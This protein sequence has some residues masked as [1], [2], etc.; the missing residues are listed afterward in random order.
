M[1]SFTSLCKTLLLYKRFFAHIPPQIWKKCFE[2]E[3]KQT[4]CQ[5][6][7]RV[8]YNTENSCISEGLALTKKQANAHE[9]DPLDIRTLQVD[10]QET[11]SD[12]G[13]SPVW[14]WPR[15]LQYKLDVHLPQVREQEFRGKPWRAHER[16]VLDLLWIATYIIV[17]QDVYFVHNKP[18]KRLKVF[19]KPVSPIGVK[20][21]DY[22]IFKEK[23]WLTPFTVY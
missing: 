17:S 8:D 4:S 18:N 6:R 1:S 11:F 20:Y 16:L 19:L 3:F 7:E 14:P 10:L 22:D 2:R 15:Q 5:A 12:R 21:S 9:V 13:M 23:H